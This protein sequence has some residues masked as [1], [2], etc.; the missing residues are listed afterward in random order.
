MSK[1]ISIKDGAN[2]NLKGIA[3]TELEV[4][5]MSL[6]YALNPDDFFGLIPRMLVKEGDKVSLGQPIFHDKN[7]ESIKIVSPVSGKI[8]EIVRG[9]KR[10]ILNVII[11]KE[12][13]NVSIL[14]YQVFQILVR[15][16]LELLVESGSLAFIR[17]RPYNI[18]AR[19]DRLPKSIFVSIHSTAP[20]AANYDFILKKRMDEFQ[21]GVDVMS[22]LIGKPINL[23]ISHNCESD[24][25]TL[26][27][28][29]VYKIKGAHPSGNESFQINR[30]D[31]LNSGEIIWV[32]KPEDLAN[33]GSFF[34]NGIFNPKRT[35]AVSGDSLRSP[36][37]YDTIIGSSIS[38]L[39]DSKELSNIK[40][41]R[42]INGDPLSG[43][44][45]EYS[46]FLRIL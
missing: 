42:F 27:N 46:D 31:P 17:Q 18:I 32:I 37:Y 12:G 19:P 34:I 23:S 9:A 24:L 38:S 2:L 4:A 10:K 15:M 21:N 11:R 36:K 14:K 20:Y 35:V 6:D 45:V 29:E 13:D 44:K 41:Y 3:S 33:I 25:S 30:I 1:D 16:I 22:K 5:K 7:N 40:N 26:N 43:S 28:V 39:V 8:L